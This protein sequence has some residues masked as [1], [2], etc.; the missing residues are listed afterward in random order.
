MAKLKVEA[1][2]EDAYEV[3]EAAAILTVGV[4]TIWRWIARGKL[5][6]FK[7]AGR[8]LVTKR[9][10]ERLQ[11]VGALAPVEQRMLSSQVIVRLEP[12]RRLSE[13]LG[14]PFY[15]ERSFTVNELLEG[16]IIDEADISRMKAGEEIK[17][18]IPVSTG[19]EQ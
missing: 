12:S 11:A 10:V 3:E 9:E 19:E 4:A 16:G 13:I 18:Q 2:I 1:E 6:S 8:T 7:V 5:S 17:K 14:F 15:I